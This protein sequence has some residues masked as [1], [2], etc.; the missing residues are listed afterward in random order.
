M[1]KLFIAAAAVAALSGFDSSP[2]KAS[3]EIFK[4]KWIDTTMDCISYASKVNCDKAFSAANAYERSLKSNPDAFVCGLL[5]GSV[6]AMAHATSLA[7]GK[8]TLQEGFENAL[9]AC[10]EY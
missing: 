7:G 8:A 4:D 10:E 6:G 2:A 5:A 9:G 3:T 1:K